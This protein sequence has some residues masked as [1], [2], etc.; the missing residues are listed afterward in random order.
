MRELFDKNINWEA[1]GYPRE[2]LRYEASEAVIGKETG[3]LDIKL[4][5]NF[6]VP[7]LD[8]ERI[9]GICSIIFRN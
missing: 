6:V 8:L 9:R 5:L 2:Q 3:V 4:R 1:V 7:H